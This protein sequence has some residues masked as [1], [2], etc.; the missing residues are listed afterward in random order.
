MKNLLFAGLVSGLTICSGVYAADEHH[1][2]HG[3]HT[4]GLAQLNIAL[5]ANTLVIELGSPA[6]NIVGFEHQPRTDEE[7]KQVDA[8]MKRLHEPVSLFIINPE[9]GCKPGQVH[10]DSEFK[11]DDHHHED[12]H[13]D[14]KSH[15]DHHEGK[16]DDHDKHAAE[17]HSDIEAQYEWHCASAGNLTRIDVRLFQ[18][19]PH[20][21]SITV[22]YIGDGGQKAANL[23]R[24]NPVFSLP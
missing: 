15:A 6:A 22:Q 11:A 23:T 21:E 20:T 13:D 9:A 4:H 8:A 19:F 14:H 10:I 5:E 16:H 3:S 2:E 7:H 24:N 17:V 1:R 12:K 18:R